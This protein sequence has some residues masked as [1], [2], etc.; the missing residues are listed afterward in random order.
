MPSGIP[1]GLRSAAAECCDS[2][3]KNMHVATATKSGRVP[4]LDRPHEPVGIALGSVVLHHGERTLPVEPSQPTID[5]IG[6]HRGGQ[7]RNAAGLDVETILAR[8]DQ[9]MRRSGTV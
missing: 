6:P 9:M 4:R 7:R 1:A 3:G 8:P 5:R 2:L